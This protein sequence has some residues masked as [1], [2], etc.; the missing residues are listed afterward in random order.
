MVIK[1]SVATMDSDSHAR[2]DTASS[3]AALIVRL[4]GPR[5][6]EVFAKQIAACATTEA[7]VTSML[8]IL[9]VTLKGATVVVGGLIARPELN[10][11]IGVVLKRSTNGRFPVKLEGADSVLLRLANLRPA[12]G[13]AFALQYRQEV[14]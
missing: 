14:G 7:R 9:D 11:R 13:T 1:E 3:Y 6:Q 5:Q 8:K 4:A 2:D 10:G 12:L